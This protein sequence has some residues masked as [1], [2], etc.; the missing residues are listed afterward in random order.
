MQPGSPCLALPP[1]GPAEML[2]SQQ[3]HSFEGVYGF[4]VSLLSQAKIA[5]FKGA[6]GLPVTGASL[7]KA[8]PLQCIT[9]FTGKAAL[10]CFSL[11]STMY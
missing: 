10:P 2:I 3:P 8:A 6:T 5:P 1:P 7:A 4:S 11:D 9:S